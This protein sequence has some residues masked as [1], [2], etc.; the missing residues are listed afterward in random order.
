MFKSIHSWPVLAS[1]HEWIL[2]F[3]CWPPN[4]ATDSSP[5]NRV[6]YSSTMCSWSRAAPAA[7][8][9][10]QL[11]TA[12]RHNSCRTPPDMCPEQQ[13]D[14]ALLQA[15]HQ[16]ALSTATSARPTQTTPTPS[17]IPNQVLP[18]AA[19]CCGV[20][21]RGVPP[22]CALVLPQPCAAPLPGRHLLGS[23]AGGGLPDA[24]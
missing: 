19:V 14:M 1:G 6:S 24:E 17:R 18:S 3:S 5:G 23:R 16:H 2:P 4:V 7:I 15:A 13:Q 10:V 8:Q 9:L 12:F 20:G 11:H 21:G 22:L